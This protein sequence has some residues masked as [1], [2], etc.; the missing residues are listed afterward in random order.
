MQAGNAMRSGWWSRL[1][2]SLF[3]AGAALVPATA[4]N[5][6]SAAAQKHFQELYEAGDYSGAFAEAQSTEALAKRRGTNNITYILALNDLARAHQMLG[7][8]ADAATMFKQVLSALQKNVPP[9]DPRIAQALANLATV[10]LLQGNNGEAERVYKQALEIVTRSLGP[11]NAAAVTLTGNLGDAY[12][13]QAR[14]VEA[15][16]QYKLALDMAQKINGPNSLQVALLLNNL[17]K[18]YEDQSRF[19]EVEEATKRALAIRE[20][21]LGPNHPDVAASLNNLAHVYERLGRYAE[22]DGMFQRA[23][24]IWQKAMGP[25]HPVL[26][27]SLLNLASVYADEGRLDEAE[28]LYKRSLSIREAVFGSNSTDAATVLNNLAAIYE[29]QERY[30]DVETFAKRALAI[31]EKSLGPEN[32]DT[33]KVLRKL[34]VAYDGERKYAEAEM[35]FNRALTIFTKVFGP[36]HR[37]V[38]TVL[39]SEG[40]LFEHQGRY[41]E[42]EQAYKQALAI[43][44]TERGVNHPEV[45]RVLHDL[46]LLNMSR[47]EP[48]NAVV[49][50]RRATAAILAHADEDVSAE[51]SSGDNSDVIKQR[52]SFFVTH[53]AS[54]AAAARVGIGSA[55]A[56]G[57]EAFEIAQ[58]ANQS[59][60]A[61]A[62]L[63]LGPRFAAGNDAL[64]ALVRTSQDLSADLRGRNRALVEAL[65]RPDGQSNATQID[66]IRKNIADTES[67]L[68]ATSAQLQKQ[69]PEFAALAHPKPLRVEEAQKRLGP[70]EALVLFLTGKNQSYV[71]ALTANGFDWHAIPIGADDL[72]EKIEKFRGGLDVDRFRQFDLNLAYELFGLLMAP[73]DALLKDKH[74]LLVVPSGAL[75]ALP[76]QLLVTDRPASAL[77]LKGPIAEED[78][79]RYRDAAWLIKRQA[80]TVLPSVPSL[81]TL[82]LL[83]HADPTMKPMIGFG[84]PV[85]NPGRTP[86]DVR[87]ATQTRGGTKSYTDYWR[88]AGID[89]S[90]LASALPSLPDTADELKVVALELGAATSDIHLGPDAS[91]TTVKHAPLADYR[92]IYFATHGLV[93]G[94]I[95]GLAEPALV[96][97]LPA[98]PT[99]ED[100]GLLTASEAAQLKLNADWV[101]LSA[102]NTMAGEKPGAPALSGLARAFFYAGARAL[103]VS[104]WSVASEAATR[105]TTSTFAALA[106]D[107]TLGRSEALRRAM[108]S[109][110]ND[111]SS[112]NNAYPAFW[113]PFSLVGEGAQ[114]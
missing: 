4:Q 108:L 18:V 74:H 103:L 33:A 80:V 17:S 106:A 54:L 81:R 68:A 20:Q 95:K 51:R 30:S 111:R 63:Q 83:G 15:E 72:A 57:Q 112:P 37:F 70:D 96:L 86:E 79:A 16:A 98:Q 99:P 67:K 11:N 77:Q 28:A 101:V 48:A 27:T 21:A 34:G 14:F 40:H 3:A 110:L 38:A 56:L 43:N 91:V 2:A 60:A 107:K 92:I 6:D 49:N 87:G 84:D 59:S 42:A 100:N 13:N 32:A 36:N 64:A 78:A 41:E 97:T 61:A 113:G 35:Q 45:A 109:Y 52:E 12:K 10:Y 26:A 19:V 1:A 114:P 69:F 7:H 93:A 102:C 66:N 58:W 22:A 50:S 55:E 94:D 104:H 82:R 47:N 39:I 71:F 62:L 46:A 76:F 25:S 31:V 24:E 65:S 89:R 85:F 8:Y 9:S 5:V 53:V 105:L 23:I 44:E 29:A 88:G 73:V 90:L 75:T